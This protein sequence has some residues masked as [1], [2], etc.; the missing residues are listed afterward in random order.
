MI[1]SELS[2]EISATD[3]ICIEPVSDDIVKPFDA[4]ASVYAVNWF[5][6][7]SS[8]FYNLYALLASKYV[9]KVSGKLHFKGTL[10]NQIEGDKEISRENL[11]I[12]SYPSPTQFLKLVSFKFF[13][14][15]SV[16]RIIAV[17]Q[18]CFG[19]T[20]RLEPALDSNNSFSFSKQQIYLVYFFQ[21]KKRGM[22]DHYQNILTTA[23][24]YQVGNYYSGLTSAKLVR[25]SSGKSQAANFNM[26]GIL[27]FAADSEEQL[28]K[29]VEDENFQSFRESNSNN[30][31]FFFNRTH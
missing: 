2:I 16:F 17:K 6:L 27:L 4:S 24:N 30:S 23:K 11:L 31:L 10:I 21:G 28:E 13:Q 12:V 20:S 19:F 1:D 18:F 8:F 14:M 3:K 29:F 5:N 15:I 7:K 26:D 22:L 25:V 9:R